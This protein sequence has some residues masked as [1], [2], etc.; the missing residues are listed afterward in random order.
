MNRLFPLI[1]VGALL[2]LVAGCASKEAVK[3]DAKSYHFHHKGYS[4]KIAWEL[5]PGHDGVAVQGLMQNIT[6]RK[7]EDM[8][9]T[10]TL[11]RGANDEVAEGQTYVLGSLKDGESTDFDLYLPKAVLTPGDR[12]AFRIKYTVPG[13]AGY[14]WAT[15]VVTDAKTGAAIVPD[16]ETTSD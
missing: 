2:F 5:V 12:L 8:E 4:F 13:A 10:A 9:V 3:K 15:N 11:L 7:V 1:L 16:N 14:T 6:L